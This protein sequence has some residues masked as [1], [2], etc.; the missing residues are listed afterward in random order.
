MEILVNE[1][2][3]RPSC[4]GQIYPLLSTGAA[5]P[6]ARYITVY[7]RQCPC[8]YLC[9]SHVT[10]V[11][12]HFVIVLY[13]CSSIYFLPH[14]RNFQRIKIEIRFWPK[15]NIQ[16]VNSAENICVLLNGCLLFGQG[17]FMQTDD[18]SA[19]NLWW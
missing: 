9:I 15:F 12:V 8:F 11:L 3:E 7:N 5:A 17:N 1:E 4:A 10:R 13:S 19:T 16:L 18:Y 6:V 14:K 2:T